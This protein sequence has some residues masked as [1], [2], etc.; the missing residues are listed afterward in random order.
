MDEVVDLDKSED[1][2][3]VSSSGDTQSSSMES[4]ACK[5]DGK[6]I[7]ILQLLSELDTG[8]RQRLQGALQWGL[9]INL[10]KQ[11]PVRDVTTV[12]DEITE[13][14]QET[15]DDRIP[16]EKFEVKEKET[17]FDLQSFLNSAYEIHCSNVII[18]L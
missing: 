10:W 17:K 3:D 13:S 4:N 12:C 6:V 8:E 14:S 5:K 16:D 9:D 2:S 18:L 1:D 11:G 7:K 15:V